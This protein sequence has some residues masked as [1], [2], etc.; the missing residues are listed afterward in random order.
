MQQVK[1][2]EPESRINPR[3]RRETV[4]AE[5]V[6][7][8]LTGKRN[9]GRT[10]GRNGIMLTVIRTMRIAIDEICAQGEL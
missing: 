8:H 10:G 6:I 9:Y 7:A 1:A 3:R 4:S 2:S 5:E